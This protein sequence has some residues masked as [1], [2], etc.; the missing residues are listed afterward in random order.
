MVSFSKAELQWIQSAIEDELKQL[1]EYLE[2]DT[3]DSPA[4]P[5]VRYIVTLRS[6]GLQVVQQKLDDV[7]KNG[8]KRIA[9]Q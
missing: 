9:I 3:E 5:L 4:D 2:K 6:E 8:R 7:L 1:S